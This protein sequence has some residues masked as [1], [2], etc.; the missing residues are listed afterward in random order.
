MVTPDVMVNYVITT[1]DYNHHTG[2]DYDT[3]NDEDDDHLYALIVL[4]CHF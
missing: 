3:E 1:A 4:L 2:A